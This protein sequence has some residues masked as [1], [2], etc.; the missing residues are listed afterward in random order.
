[1]ALISCPECG[2]Q[3][4]DRSLQCP[5]CGLTKDE[6]EKIM[7]NESVE[8]DSH[9]KGY[10]IEL[11]QQ[12]SVL[13]ELIKEVENKAA[14]LKEMNA[15]FSQMDEKIRKNEVYL[16]EQ[17]AKL[18]EKRKQLDE[19]FSELT[20]RMNDQMSKMNRLNEELAH[21][22]KTINQSNICKNRGKGERVLVIS[23]S[24]ALVAVMVWIISMVI[25]TN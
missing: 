8:S 10:S 7:N 11:Y 23:L 18:I 17:E 25:R 3:I 14:T 16:R 12:Q 5:Q 20:N 2:K 1:M 22:M 21:K 4:S 15:A 9:G 19:S 13:K 24:I 6:R